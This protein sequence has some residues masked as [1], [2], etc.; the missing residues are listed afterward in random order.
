MLLRI[1]PRD[2]EAADGGESLLA[3][4]AAWRGGLIELVDDD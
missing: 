2:A 1:L 4:S 3:S